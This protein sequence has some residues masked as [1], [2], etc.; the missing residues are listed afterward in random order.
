M[1]IEQ[2]YAACFD[3]RITGRY[4]T[5]EM[6]FPILQEYQ[7]ELQISIVGKSENGK[8]IPLLRLG[9]GSRTVLMWSQMHGNESTTTKAIL[10]LLRFF[11]INHQA[12]HVASFFSRNT[13][14]IIP[15]LNP[16]GAEL[17]TRANANGVDLNRDAISLSQKE[18]RVLREVFDT[19]KPD[20]C[21]NMHGQRSLFGLL[22]GQPAGISFLSPSVDEARS[23]TPVRIDAMKEIVKMN[24]LL[25]RFLPGQ[26]GRY[27]DGF[28]PNCVGDQFQMQN[29]PTIL[30]EAGHVAGDYHR[31]VSRKYIF[32]ALFC[33]FELGGES[34]LENVNESMYF[35]I[36]ENQKNYRDILIRNVKID[37]E[38]LPVDIAVQYEEQLD[39]SAIKFVPKIDAIGVLNH[40]H[41][42]REIDFENGVLATKLNKRLTKGDV[43]HKI[44]K[45]NNDFIVNFD[46]NVF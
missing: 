34:R 1:N 10:D 27:D 14:Y 24:T 36:P 22:T 20:L 38:S 12:E 13:L 44:H 37:S 42:H 21:L 26:I 41:G 30:F 45:N 11:K 40:L 17:Y 2:E 25:Q 33:L 35:A 39:A 19:V 29:V 23:V 7:N 8:P 6:I 32:Y 9:N 5:L 4:V 43:I 31:E 18:S 16:D 46:L 28:N 3:E 15:I